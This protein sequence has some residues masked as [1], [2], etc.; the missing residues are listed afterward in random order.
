[1]DLNN[2]PRCCLVVACPLS[3]FIGKH[4]AECFPNVE[5]RWGLCSWAKVVEF[6][7]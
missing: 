6:R 1:M 3:W 2:V 7:C 4:G 5:P